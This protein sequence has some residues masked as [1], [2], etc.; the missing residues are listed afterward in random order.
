MENINIIW[1]SFLVTLIVFFVLYSIFSK[2]VEVEEDDGSIYDSFKPKQRKTRRTK[3]PNSNPKKRVD[4]PSHRKDVIDITS[5][6]GSPEERKR[7][8]KPKQ[9]PITNKPKPKKKTSKKKQVS[10]KPTPKKIENK[11][12]ETLKKQTPPKKIENKPKIERVTN[13]KK[14][15]KPKE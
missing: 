12:K 7:I 6:G 11:P 1:I 5:K 3:I 10:M 13:S 14:D 9:K 8:F 2:N 15:S 4:K